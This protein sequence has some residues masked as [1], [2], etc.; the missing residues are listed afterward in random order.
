VAK[1]REDAPFDRSVTSAARDEPASAPVHHP[2][3]GAGGERGGVRLG[4]IGLNLV[5]GSEDGGRQS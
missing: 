5:H 3:S 2:R 1:I 4:G